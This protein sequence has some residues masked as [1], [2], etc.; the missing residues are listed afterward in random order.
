M[1]DNGGYRT[2]SLH[3]EDAERLAFWI[4]R[5]SA[6]LR[7]EVVPES[8]EEAEFL[9]RMIAVLHTGKGRSEAVSDGA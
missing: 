3:G 9:D 8:Q 4:D 7:Q 5:K 6:S 1:S 2:V